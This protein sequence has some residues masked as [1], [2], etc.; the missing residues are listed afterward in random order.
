MQN[1]M[2]LIHSLG[3]ILIS[4]KAL[5]KNKTIKGCVFIDFY[6]LYDGSCEEVW[7][8]FKLKKV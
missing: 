1:P 6:S 2:L 3:I 4:L 8:A 5:I 7:L